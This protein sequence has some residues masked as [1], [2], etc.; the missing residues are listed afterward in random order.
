M[1]SLHMRATD[2]AC[3]AEKQAPWLVRHGQ[4]TGHGARDAFQ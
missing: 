3:Q 4:N 2:L 1:T